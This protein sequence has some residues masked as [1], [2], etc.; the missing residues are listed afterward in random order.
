MNFGSG[1]KEYPVGYSLEFSGIQS[2]CIAGGN[3]SPD[4]SR[5]LRAL[6]LALQFHSDWQSILRNRLIKQH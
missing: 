5:S 6:N 3:V 1:N 4:L 2:H